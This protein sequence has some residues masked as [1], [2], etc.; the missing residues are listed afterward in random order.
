[1]K[2]I[3]ISHKYWNVNKL[4]LRKRLT[5]ISNILEKQGH[6]TFIY[7]RDF[8]K[9]VNEHSDPGVALKDALKELKKCDAVVGVVFHKQISQGMLLEYGYAKALNKKTIL[10]VYD[11]CPSPVLEHLS[12]K[13]IRFKNKED[14]EK[15]LKV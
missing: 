14:L 3:F 7:F 8:Q 12:D 1:M 6:K 13:V 10:L 4:I 9:W 2:Y 5:C 15:K 11:K